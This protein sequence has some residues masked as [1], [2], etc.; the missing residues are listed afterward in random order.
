MIL[1]DEIGVNNSS[2]KFYDGVDFDILIKHSKDGS[3]G[4]IFC[5]IDN[6]IKEVKSYNRQRK[7]NSIVDNIKYINFEWEMIDNNYISIYQVEGTGIEPV[8]EAVKNKVSKN[9]LTNQPSE[10][11]P[12]QNIFI[13]PWVSLPLIDGNLRGA[14]RI[15]NNRK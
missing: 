2:F 11:I 6:W 15:D 5:F 1:I 7:L 10:I 4:F 12:P 9:Q 14:W 3:D 13:S 8:L